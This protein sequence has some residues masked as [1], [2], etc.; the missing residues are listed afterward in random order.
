MKA[1]VIEGI[2]ESEKEVSKKVHDVVNW[3]ILICM[4]IGFVIYANS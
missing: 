4:L 1:T 2:E 3:M